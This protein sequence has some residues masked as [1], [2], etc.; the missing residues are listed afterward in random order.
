MCNHIRFYS[1]LRLTDNGAVGAHGEAAVS[2]VV[3]EPNSAVA[4]VRIPALIMEDLIVQDYQLMTRIVEPMTVQLT[5]SIY[6]YIYILTQT[7]AFKLL[8]FTYNGFYGSI[9]FK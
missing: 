3:E 6:I 4:S 9:T 2:P 5:V 7:D 1:Q 8:I